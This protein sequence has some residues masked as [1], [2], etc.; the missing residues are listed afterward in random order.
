MEV[1]LVKSGRFVAGI[2]V[3]FSDRRDWSRLE[4][5]L[6]EETA[7]RTWAALEQVRAEAALRAS[8]DARRLALDAA[9]LGAFNI[10]LVS[11]TL[12]TDE[13][14]RIIF[15]GTTEPIGYEQAFAAIHPDDRGRIRDAVAAATR[16][17]DPAPYAEE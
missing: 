1:P 11:H 14:F 17:E 12:D 9:E 2:T 4:V 6:I 10:D 3:N 8:E 13:R 5:S 15:A 7:E 16:A